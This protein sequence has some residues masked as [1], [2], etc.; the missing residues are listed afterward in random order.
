MKTVNEIIRDIREDRQLK[1]SEVAE[2]LNVQQSYYSKYE[3]GEYEFPARHVITLARY[4]NVT[5]DYLLGLTDYSH[6][7]EELKK[8]LFDNMTTG[9]LLSDV[10]KLGAN[11]RKAVVE[12]VQLMLLKKSRDNAVE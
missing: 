5:A 2:V 1:Q 12:Y 11:G 7:F 3:T 8:P 6:N 10:L 9:K 4:Y